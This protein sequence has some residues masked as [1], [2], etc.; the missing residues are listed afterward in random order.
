MKNCG[1]GAILCLIDCLEFVISV[2][3][4]ELFAN[5][6]AL[7]E[8]ASRRSVFS[9]FCLDFEIREI[10]ELV[11]MAVGRFMAEDY[12]LC[13][14]LDGSR[15]ILHFSSGHLLEDFWVKFVLKIGIIFLI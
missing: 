9:S 10:L 7:L 5:C 13:Q 1:C 4:W 15:R 6:F 12:N 2:R 11:F 3:I 14:E 8:S